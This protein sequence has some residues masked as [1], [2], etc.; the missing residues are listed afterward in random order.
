MADFSTTQVIFLYTGIKPGFLR[1]D[2]IHVYPGKMEGIMANFST[3]SR[4]LF[5]GI[6]V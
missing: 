6:Q 2:K 3:P 1:P 4:R 5:P